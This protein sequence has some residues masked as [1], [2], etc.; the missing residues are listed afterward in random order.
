MKKIIKPCVILLFIFLWSGM[1]PLF[2][3]PDFRGIQS[4][5]DIQITILYDN[6]IYT[7]E[8]KLDWG[9]S[10]FVQ[11]TEKT[12]LFDA[13]TRPEVFWH[14]VKILGINI[15]SVDAIVISHEHG[16]HT[17]ALQTF[18]E[19]KPDVEVYAPASFSKEFFQKVEETG[20]RVIKVKEPVEICEGV[21]STGEMGREIIEQAL[22]F[23]NAAGLTVMT[24]CAHPGIVGIVERAGEIHNQ[25]VKFVFG[26]FHLMQKT[27][28]QIQEIIDRFQELGVVRCGATHCTGEQQIEWFRRAFGEN[29][30]EMGVGRIIGLRK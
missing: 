20:A 13:G 24:G 1:P 10:A 23:K 21:F 25:K 7:P 2:S 11:G 27:Q 4:A 9:F 22:I 16:D 18:L 19:K 3:A 8:T 29:F 12:I 28:G 15:T 6:T 17:G 26:G 30:A 5:G 14:N